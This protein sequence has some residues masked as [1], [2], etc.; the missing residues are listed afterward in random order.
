MRH[1]FL[2]AALFLVQA[3]VYISFFAR[4]PEVTA[5]LGIG[6]TALGRALMGLSL[7]TVAGFL[8]AGAI[9]AR[10]GARRASAAGLLGAAVMLPWAISGG[11]DHGVPG[12]ALCFALYGAATAVL[13]VGKNLIAVRVEAVT[14][15]SVMARSHG[16]WSVGLFL[17]TLL[18]GA[19]VG[20]GLSALFQQLVLSALALPLAAWLVLGA[21]AEPVA[22]SPAGPRFVRPDRF[23]ACL[24]LLVLGFSITEGAVYDWAMFYLRR[25]L[26]LA[27]GTPAV[28]YAC[29]T[30]GMAAMRMA[31]DWLRRQL[32]LAAM[33]RLM[34]VLVMAGL[35]VM[36]L[37]PRLAAAGGLGSLAVAGLAL[38]MVLL[39]AGVALASPLAAGIALTQPGRPAAQ[40]MAA[41][42]LAS[43]VA[44]FSLPPM[45][46]GVVEHAGAIWA[47]AAAVPLLTFVLWRAPA[48]LRRMEA[49]PPPA[50]APAPRA[51]Q[52][53][54]S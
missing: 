34:A 53:A 1:V 10:F 42:A 51:P 38:G 43:L 20:L 6:P 21:A 11:Y 33:L 5:S 12:M 39:G 22:P 31:G 23:V 50:A 4:L 41:Y 8:S 36:A 45:L 35:A 52:V 37:V 15:R 48:V 18:S 44:T 13:E 54:L 14:G 3:L 32:A 26:A 9:I 24:L 29:F 27:S 47:M 28:I 25:D 2:P 17:G 30:L 7:G 19:A 16:F 46:G 49:L 40:T